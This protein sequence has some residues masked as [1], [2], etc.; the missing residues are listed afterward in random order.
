MFSGGAPP[1]P[2]ITPPSP[3]MRIPQ[4]IVE[5][6]F[7]YLYYDS[8]AL[9]SCSLTCY[10]WY[11][12]AVP[13]LH[14]T[15]YMIKYLFTGKHD[16]PSCIRYKHML[17]LLPLVKTVIIGTLCSFSDTSFSPKWF[18]CCTLRQ[19]MTLTNVQTLQIQNLDIPSFMPRIRRYFRPFLPTLQ[20][21]QLNSPIG[22]NRQIIF[23]V[24]LFQQLQT[25]SLNYPQLQER[26]PDDLTLTPPF[27]PPLRGKLI[28][29]NWTKEGF[30]QDMVRLFG[31]IGFHDMELFDVDGTRFL[32]RACAKTLSSLRLHPNDPLGEQFYLK[33]V[34]F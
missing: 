25:L 19:F 34:Q 17:G 7:R 10:S 5:T 32:L 15:F 18:N 1:T 4:E 12:A 6:I 9:R 20:A 21:L 31:G 14:S 29:L 33:H 13:H 26:E 30:F 8:P 11:I 27:A 22:S 16:W 23:F 2:R 3:A 24:G 28:V